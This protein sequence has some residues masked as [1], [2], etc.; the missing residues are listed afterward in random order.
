VGWLWL[1][2]GEGRMC[3]TIRAGELVGRLIGSARCLRYCTGNDGKKFG[4][5]SVNRHGWKCR[6]KRTAI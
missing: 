4:D 3:V 2:M 6:K 5:G 1:A